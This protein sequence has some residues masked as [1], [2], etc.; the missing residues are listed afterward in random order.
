MSE[1]VFRY[2]VSVGGLLDMCAHM[3]P[4]IIY[5]AFQ[6]YLGKRPTQM[7]KF[8]FGC[9]KLTSFKRKKILRI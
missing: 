3:A 6:K 8:S 4:P 5:M 1:A 9:E 2:E 7:K